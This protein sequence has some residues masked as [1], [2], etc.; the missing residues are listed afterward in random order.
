[1]LCAKEESRDTLD[2][3]AALRAERYSTNEH[4]F[5]RYIRMIVGNHEVVEGVALTQ[6]GTGKERPCL[7]RR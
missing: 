3:E 6:S 4:W 1:M 7:Q 5:G 2:V